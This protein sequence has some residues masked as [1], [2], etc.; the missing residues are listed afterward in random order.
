MGAPIDLTGWR[1]GMLTVVSESL[2]RLSGPQRCWVCQCDCGR[3]TIVRGQDLRTGHTTS[4]GC[5]KAQLI[6]KGCH[7]THGWSKD[8][9][10]PEY[11]IWT[12][13]NRRCTN[14][15]EDN[16]K[17]YGAMGVTVSPL[18]RHDFPAFLAH[19]GPRPS[20]KHSI[21]RINPWGHY[22]PGNVRWATALEQRHNRREH[23]PQPQTSAPENLDGPPKG[24]AIT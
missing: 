1:V 8:R 19:V 14:P 10:T 5:Y 11:K 18:W 24:E 21:D 13:I 9:G 6:A 15:N 4:C 22:E 16:Y 23:H 7:T 20:P 17:Y 3:V 12:S 2:M